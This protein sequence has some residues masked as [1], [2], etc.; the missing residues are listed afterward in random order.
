MTTTGSPA[1]AALP[2]SGPTIDLPTRLGAWVGLAAIAIMAAAI[3]IM[4]WFTGGNYATAAIAFLVSVL[5]SVAAGSATA[6]VVALH[7]NRPVRPVTRGG[8]DAL[9][10]EVAGE[11]LTAFQAGR[12][13]AVG[14]VAGQRLTRDLAGL[15]GS[16]WTRVYASLKADGLL[17]ENDQTTAALRVWAIKQKG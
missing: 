8:Q 11:E 6:F 4:A 3:V 1:W 10:Y 9:T 14:W 15:S 12:I 7:L 16:R 2:P 17:D 13:S 5:L